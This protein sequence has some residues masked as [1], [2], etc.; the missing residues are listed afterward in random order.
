M[1]EGEAGNTAQSGGASAASSPE[2][3]KLLDINKQFLDALN[4]FVTLKQKKP[5]DYIADMISKTREYGARQKVFP[6]KI[7]GLNRCIIED[8][9][10]R[11][12]TDMLASLA[13]QKN[14]RPKNFNFDLLRQVCEEQKVQSCY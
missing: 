13:E 9:S 12:L 4:I 10:D 14:E 11:T 6:S 8:F 1:S 5:S 7:I 2:Q 3:A